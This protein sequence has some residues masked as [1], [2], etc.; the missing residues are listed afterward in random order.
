MA[1]TLEI[2]K[3]PPQSMTVSVARACFRDAFLA[4]P[5]DYL[6][7]VIGEGDQEIIGSAPWATKLQHKS[8]TYTGSLA[9]AFRDPSPEN[10]RLLGLTRLELMRYCRVEV[11]AVNREA[12]QHL[13]TEL[14][15]K[16]FDLEEIL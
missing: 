5:F 8:L 2:Q 3:L 12:A 14:T 10:K 11:A 13:C 1:T 15:E 16:L 6:V 4:Q 9:A 7:N